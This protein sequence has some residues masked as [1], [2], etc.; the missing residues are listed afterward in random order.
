MTYRLWQHAQEFS[1]ILALV[2]YKHMFGMHHYW[3]MMVM[4]KTLKLLIFIIYLLLI[5]QL[6]FIFFAR[7]LRNLEY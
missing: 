7:K 3:N 1:S 2:G 6:F 4:F 5:N